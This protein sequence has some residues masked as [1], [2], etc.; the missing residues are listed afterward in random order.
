MKNFCRGILN[1]TAAAVSAFVFAVLVLGSSCGDTDDPDLA[2]G[3][4]FPLSGEA[5]GI[6]ERMR[7]GVELA[8]EEVNTSSDGATLPLRLVFKDTQSTKDGAAAAFKELI[9]KEAVGAIIGPWSSSSTEITAPIA[10]ESGVVAISPTSAASPDGITAPG[11]FIFR[12]SLTVDKLV[13]DGISRTKSFLSYSKAATIV[14]EEDK[15]SKSGNNKVLEVLEKDHPDVE[16]VT[17]QT[18]S[19]EKNDPLPDLAQQLTAIKESGA[20]VVFVSAL[21]DGREGMIVEARK[22]DIHVPLVIILLTATDVAAAEEKLEGSTENV[23]TVTSWVADSKSPFVS[24][25][26]AKYGEAPDAYSARAYASAGVLAAAIARA[27]TASSEDIRVALQMMNSPETGLDTILSPEFYFDE[28]GDGF[29]SPVVKMVSDG[30]FA[31]I[32]SGDG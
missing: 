18:F 2:I 24:S 32:P 10:N 30:K 15:F 6:G 7:K 27:S 22:M 20:D 28:N 16:I 4:A 23:F 5:Q 26:S 19:R 12:T 14:N 9:D 31:D 3:V 25:Y 1:K 8:V 11:D 13:P 29:Y 17:R 21:S